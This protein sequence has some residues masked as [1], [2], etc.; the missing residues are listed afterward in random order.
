MPIHDGNEI[1]PAAF[2]ADIGNV[3]AP[4]L[5]SATAVFG[6][7]FGYRMERWLDGTRPTDPLEAQLRRLP[8][9]NNEELARRAESIRSS[10]GLPLLLQFEIADA[11]TQIPPDFYPLQ[12][13]L[14][15]EK[16][17]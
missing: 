2:H 10:L 7:A 14:Q 15:E 13:F 17:G 8:G 5:Q 4:D 1:H 6:F 11:I 16:S 12:F 9:R 3:S